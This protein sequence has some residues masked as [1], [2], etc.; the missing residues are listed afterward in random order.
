MNGKWLNYGGLVLVAVIWGA[1][2]GISRLA[3]ESFHPIVFSVLRFGLAVPFFFLLLWRK[4]GSVG[5]PWRLVPRLA[6]IGLVGI[7]L[8]EI[9]VMYSIKFTTLANASLLNV[10]PWPIFAAL[11]AP[12]FLRE[13]ITVRLVVGGAVSMVGVCFVILG[14][15]E[16]FN[17]SP[18]NM[19]GNAMALGVSIIGALFNLSTMSLMKQ[20]SALRVSTWTIAFG[21]LFM[22]PL[23]AGGAWGQT[24]WAGLGAGQYAS[25]AYNVLIC[26]VVAFLVWNASMFKVG[27]T[28]SNFFRYAVPAAAVAAG[29]FMFDETITLL[30]LCGAACMAA[31][32]VWISVERKQAQPQLQA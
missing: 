23:T 25:I 28:R 24:D 32:L 8:L 20:Y 2:F 16:G 30:Q 26:T 18:E 29:Y 12:L 14:G 19:L 4:E 27:A 13:S 6:L 31:G 17:L 1:N 22:L 9:T 5:I 10:A 3:M 21:S 15:Q 7:T 11:F